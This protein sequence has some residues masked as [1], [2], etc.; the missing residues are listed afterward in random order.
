[1]S[2]LLDGGDAT[3]ASLLGRSRIKGVADALHRRSFDNEEVEIEPDTKRDIDDEEVQVEADDKRSVEVR[4]LNV[5]MAH[6]V[7]REVEDEEV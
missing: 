2:S 1:M 6:T 4:G 3:P 7:A 5:M